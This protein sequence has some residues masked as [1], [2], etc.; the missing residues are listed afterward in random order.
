MVSALFSFEIRLHKPPYASRAMYKVGRP[1]ARAAA[2]QGTGLDFT[3]VDIADSR[4]HALIRTVV[5]DCKFRPNSG[6]GASLRPT[7][8][9]AAVLFASFWA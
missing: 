8:I 3:I 5:P 2:L 1:F 9:S 4:R 7:L 6:H